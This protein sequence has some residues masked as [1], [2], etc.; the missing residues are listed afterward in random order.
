MSKTTYR[1]KAILSRIHQALNA[2][3]L[4]Q[5]ID[6][7]YN[8]TESLEKILGL[9]LEEI[10]QAT[11]KWRPIA[12]RFIEEASDASDAGL[13][14]S[15]LTRAAM[16]IWQHQGKGK[17]K[18]VDKLFKQALKADPRAAAYFAA[19]SASTVELTAAVEK[20]KRKFAA[21]YSSAMLR[22]SGMIAPFVA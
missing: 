21:A 4:L 7:K 12:D 3:Y 14:A 15:M 22:E 17:T 20:D 18:E 11:E 9:A 16:L 6:W 13:K 10:E 19:R 1:R 5:K 2:F 8:I